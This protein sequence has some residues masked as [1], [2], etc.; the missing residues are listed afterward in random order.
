MDYARTPRLSKRS[1]NEVDDIVA[2]IVAEV[3]GPYAIVPFVETFNKELAQTIAATGTVP[4]DPQLSEMLRA[5]R[6]T[7]FNPEAGLW[8]ALSENKQNLFATA[9]NVL[10]CVQAGV[11]MEYFLA[12]SPQLN[13]AQIKESWEAKL[14]TEYAMTVNQ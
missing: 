12:L 14:P 6:S 8:L 1:S 5:W 3:G 4:A 10:T 7:G 2:G 13:A 9:R 11:Q